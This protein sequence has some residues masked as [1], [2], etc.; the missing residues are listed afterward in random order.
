[1]EL[2]HPVPEHSG[3]PYLVL[4]SHLLVDLHPSVLVDLGWGAKGLLHI[5]VHLLLLLLDILFRATSEQCLSPKSRLLHL[6][7]RFLLKFLSLL[8]VF[9]L[10]LLECVLACKHSGDE[11]Y[12]ILDEFRASLNLLIVVLHSIFGY[13][14][15][16]SWQK[17][18]ENSL[19]VVWI[20]QVKLF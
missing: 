14:L 15:L 16:Q 1:M 20:R 12:L 3:V 19:V 7:Q 17:L 10:D 6:N 13:S 4:W 5:G 9:F 8:L 2:L 18:L 11:R